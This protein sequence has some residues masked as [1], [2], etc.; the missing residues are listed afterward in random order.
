MARRLGKAGGITAT[1]HKLAGILN[2]MIHY[3]QTL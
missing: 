1:A 2:A 3:P